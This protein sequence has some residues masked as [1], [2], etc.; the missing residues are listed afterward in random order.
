MVYVIWLF[1]KILKVK[2]ND[3]KNSNWCYSMHVNTCTDVIR[4]NPHNM[5]LKKNIIAMYRIINYYTEAQ[6][7]K[8]SWGDTLHT[9]SQTHHLWCLNERHLYKSQ[10]KSGWIRTWILAVLSPSPIGWRVCSFTACPLLKKQHK[11]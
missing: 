4:Y 7:G 9:V 1:Q 10:E 6:S 5:S 3:G 2:E 8:S 11:N